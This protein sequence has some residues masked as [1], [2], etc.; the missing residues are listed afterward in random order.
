M[1]PLATSEQVRGTVAVHDFRLQI[2]WLVRRGYLGISV[3]EAA[4]R[5]RR[6][7][8]QQ[9]RAVVLTFDDGYRSVIEHAL[10]VL[11]ESGFTATLY[12][13]TAAMDRTTDWYVKKGGR[14]FPHASWNELENAAKRGFDIGSHS[15]DHLRLSKVADEVL[16]DQ[17]QRSR[18]EIAQRVGAC[19]HFAYP[20]GDVSEKVIQATKA[21]GYQTAV[22][23][24]KGFNTPD[25][26]PFELRRQMVS[27]TTSLRRFRRKVGHWW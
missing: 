10:P 19:D 25:T 22:T 4:A 17:L 21:A 8:P 18:A 23:T 20:F 14:A 24:L 13:V 1:L 27:R 15:V 7:D 9:D 16:T 6:D 5:L 26:A 11:E 2:E 3:S 12:I